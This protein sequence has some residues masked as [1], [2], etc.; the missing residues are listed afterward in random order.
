MSDIELLNEI[1]SLQ[2]KYVRA[3]DKRDWA[4]WLDC[5]DPQDGSYICISRENVEQNM[6]IA[7]MLD[8]CTARLRDRVTFITK[9]WTGTYEDYDTRHFIQRLEHTS[10][11]SKLYTVQTNFL[12]AYTAASGASEVLAA[13]CYED[14][15]RLNPEGPKFISKRAI[16]D[17][18][19]T[20]RYLVYPI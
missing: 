13:G 15:I 1:D 17:T 9:V 6:P 19:S 11:D 12:I 16:L 18:V 3:L 20:P 5:F 7:L 2:T 8:D 14:L 4:S 10:S